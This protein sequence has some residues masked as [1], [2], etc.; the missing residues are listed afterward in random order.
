M[1]DRSFPRR[2]ARAIA[3]LSLLVAAVPLRADV[4]QWKFINK[5]GQHAQD[6]HLKWEGD[7]SWPGT[8]TPPQQPANTFAAAHGNGSSSVGLA[9]AQTGTGVPVQAPAASV[10]ID[11][12][13][14]G[15]KPVLTEAWWTFT[16]STTE[17]ELPG[18][19]SP[20]RLK[21]SPGKTNEWAMAPA[22]G[23]GV[24]AVTLDDVVTQFYTVSG[25]TGAQTAA[26]FG[27]LIDS[28]PFGEVLSLNDSRISFNGHSYNDLS[29]NIAVEIIQQDTTQPV[30]VTDVPE[31]AAA[32]SILSLTAVALARRRKL[33]N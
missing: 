29:P 22:T 13:Y 12:H 19:P 9:M 21:V 20:I 17:L 3:M 14:T 11:F 16:N 26:R 32:G 31:P 6:L 23:D 8:G 33:S 4:D 28:T 10:V 30:I 18:M 15:P 1:P 5:T 2:A 7:V 25:E 24:L 27:A